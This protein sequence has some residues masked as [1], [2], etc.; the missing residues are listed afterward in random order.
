MA[1]STMKRVIP[2]ENEGGERE[3]NDDDDEEEQGG[4]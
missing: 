3:D 2:V 4:D 1:R